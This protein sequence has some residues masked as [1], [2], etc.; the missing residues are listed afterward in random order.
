M[1]RNIKVDFDQSAELSDLISRH[2]DQQRWAYNMAVREKLNDPRVTKYDLDG[3]LT[4]WRDERE[5]LVH[6]KE[7]LAAG[8]KEACNSRVQRTGLRQGLDAVEKFM[9]SNGKKRRNKSLWKYLARRHREKEGIPDI[10]TAPNLPSNRWSIKRNRWSHTNDLFKMKGEQL[11]LSVFAKPVHKGNNM[12]MLPGIG[13]VRVHGDVEGL[14]MRSFQLV[15]TTR[16]TTKRTK[17]YHRTYRLHIQIEIKAP[18]PS[19]YDTIRG[20]DM[21]IVHGAATV[22]LGTGNHTF[23]DLP[24]DCRGPRMTTYPGCMQSSQG[25]GGDAGTGAPN[26]TPR[27]AATA[28]TATRAAVATALTTRAA[29]TGTGRGSPSPAATGSSRGRSARSAKSL[30]TARPTGSD[31]RQ[32]R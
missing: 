25:S 19:K 21:G 11:S 2:M 8:R 7:A 28:G 9:I 14:D 15:E 20:V 4:K 26:M 5:W 22:D 10:D 32:R 30:P 6:D 27:R 29:T 1:I 31:T 12:V 18:K 23:H 13:T 17:N 24:K 3:M 16:K